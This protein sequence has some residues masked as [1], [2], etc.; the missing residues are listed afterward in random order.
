MPVTFQSCSLGKLC[1]LRG[2]GCPKD[3]ESECDRRVIPTN[4]F[5]SGWDRL[6]VNI[7]STT[8]D[9]IQ[10]WHSICPLMWSPRSYLLIINTV[11]IKISISHQS[12]WVIG[13]FLLSEEVQIGDWQ[14]IPQNA[15]SRN[16]NFNPIIRTVHD[17]LT[18]SNKSFIVETRNYLPFLCLNSKGLEH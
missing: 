18:V 17:C 5:K 3:P 8:M 15:I 12:L 1:I 14:P 2:S 10:Y 7:H 9:A 16:K 11:S 6:N 4:W 13:K